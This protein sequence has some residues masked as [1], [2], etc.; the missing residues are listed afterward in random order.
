[1]VS[2]NLYTP[3]GGLFSTHVTWE[4]IEEDMQRVLYTEASFGPQKS[5]KDIGDGN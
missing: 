3:A 4:D 1:M 2:E 5:I